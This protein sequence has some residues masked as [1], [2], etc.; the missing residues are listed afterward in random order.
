MQV[1]RESVDLVQTII[2]TSSGPGEPDATLASLA[3]RLK[4]RSEDLTQR[5]RRCLESDRPERVFSF[6]ARGGGPGL[7]EALRTQIGTGSGSLPAGTVRC[8]ALLTARFQ[9]RVAASEIRGAI[10]AHASLAQ[11]PQWKSV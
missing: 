3:Q 4:E 1:L 10:M 8:I 2:A 9:L 5:A 7:A 6:D 11:Q